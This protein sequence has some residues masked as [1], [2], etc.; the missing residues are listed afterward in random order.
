MPRGLGSHTRRGRHIDSSKVKGFRHTCSQQSRSKGFETSNVGI[1]GG[2][3]EHSINKFVFFIANSQRPAFLRGRRRRRPLHTRRAD[4]HHY[5]HTHTPVTPLRIHQHTHRHTPL[6]T[7]HSI[8]T[9]THTPCR[10]PLHTTTHTPLHI[11]RDTWQAGKKCPWGAVRLGKW[12]NH[13]GLTH[14]A[15]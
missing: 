15:F 5:T 11:H 4:T 9:T 1:A 13:R 3:I 2:R 12:R 6:H 8:H 14:A 10:T 7:H